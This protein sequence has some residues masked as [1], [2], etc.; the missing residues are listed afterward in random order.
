MDGHRAADDVVAALLAH[1]VTDVFAL[2]GEENLPVVSALRRADV[3]LVVC[4]HEQHAGF[5]AVA[6]ARLTG[7]IGVCLVT[8]GPGATN[9]FTPLAQAHLI[10]A[11]L[12]VITGQKALRDNEEGP[13][14][15]IDVV[16]AATPITGW[17]SSISDPEQAIE[18]TLEALRAAAGGHRAALLEIPEDVASARTDPRTP[19]RTVTAMSRP[20]ETSLEAAAAAINAADRPVFLVGNAATP[21]RTSGALTRFAH[22]TGIS[23]IA[24]QMGKGAVDEAGPHAQASLG[25]H[26]EDYSH[27]ALAEADLVIAVGYQPV[28]HPPRAWNTRDLPIIHLHR[29]DAHVVPG[30]VPSRELIGD[31]ATV[32]DDLRPSIDRVDTRWSEEVAAAVRR[33]LARER[34]DILARGSE[35]GRPPAIA[36]VEAVQGHVGV[37]HVVALDNGL[38]KI[39][40]ARHFL[41]PRPHS[42]VMDNATASMGAGLA[43]AMEAARLGR[44]AIAIVG[45]GGLLM[46]VGDLETACRLG[47]DLT[48][49]V[50]RDDGFGFIAWHQDEQGRERTG[51]DLGNPDLVA[52]AQAFGGTGLRVDAAGPLSEC[53]RQAEGT[54][55]VVLID[56]PIS[57]SASDVLESDDLLATATAMLRGP[58]R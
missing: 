13:F 46:N 19:R 11:P 39:W 43:T 52:L 6:H 50:A 22:D 18:R 51:V 44:P 45:D 47:L 53:L 30:Y 15:V 21:P 41:S 35:D 23:V 24:T 57:Y 42:L 38:Y 2:P 40:F 48:I 32:L 14:Q 29:E 12:L 31:I 33:C 5:M 1:G 36:V 9:A 25:M 56:C 7:R 58:A 27:L 4:R 37:D 20:D 16:G 55:G 34:D 8:L 26:R 49:V 28:G 10:G 17:A 3:P 54:P